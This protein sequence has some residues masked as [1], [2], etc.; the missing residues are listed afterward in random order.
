MS[1]IG[2]RE[3]DGVSGRFYRDFLG[4]RYWF[5]EKRG[6]YVSQRGGR[7]SMLH[8]VAFGDGKSEVIP[9]DGDWENF[10]PANWQLRARNTGRVKESSREFQEFNGLRFYRD[11]D[12]GYYSRR[13]PRTEFMHRYVWSFHNGPIPDGFHIHHR[14]EDKADNRI[15][16]LE[17][18]S[19]SEH[20]RHHSLDSEW[21]G[22][23]ANRA[24]LAGV[25]EKAAEWHRSE[26]GR[27][28]HREHGK[29][30]WENRPMHRRSCN[31]CGQE[32]ETPYPTRSQF[33]SPRCKQRAAYRR[34]AVGV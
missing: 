3:F 14:N 26:V 13:Y 11:P 18:L 34:K 4:V 20:V 24:Q 29:R 16:N 23:D 12:N 9:V 8:R 17:L 5:W 6:F 33:C 27:S 28:W 15:E 31:C 19:A 25:R 7:Q 21:I 1:A 32:Y 22:S 10:D 30:S 2:P